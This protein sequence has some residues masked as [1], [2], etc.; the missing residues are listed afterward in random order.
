MANPIKAL[1]EW[2][3]VLRKDGVLLMILP[4]RDYTFDWRRPVTVVEH[5]KKDYELGPRSRTL[6]IWK[7][8]WHC[9]I[10]PAIRV[11]ARQNSSKSGA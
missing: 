3:R 9:T 7:K 4:H 11:A 8:F 1:L 6:R 10:Y 2:K 5:M